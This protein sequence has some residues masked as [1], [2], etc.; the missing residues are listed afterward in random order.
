MLAVTGEKNQSRSHNTYAKVSQ[1]EGLRKKGNYSKQS[2][3]FV[4]SE[5]SKADRFLEC[6]KVCQ[7]EKQKLLLLAVSCISY[8]Q[9][10]ITSNFFFFMIICSIETNMHKHCFG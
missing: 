7:S 5:S 9:I 3:L 2:H 6:C 8:M 1:S 4:S 10:N